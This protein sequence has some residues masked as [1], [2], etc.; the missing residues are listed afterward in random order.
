MEAK[1]GLGLSSWVRDGAGRALTVTEDGVASN[2]L[3]DG[4]QVVAEGATQLTLAPNGQT[5]SETTTTTTTKG[6]NTTTTVTSVDVL[7]DVLGSAVA[8]ASNGVISADLALFG[9]FGDPLTTSKT[10]T[11]TGFTGKLD[12]AGL[13]EFAVRTFDP[14]TRQWVQ[15]DRYRGTVTRAASMNRYAYVEGAPETFVD[16]LGFYRARAAIRAQALAAWEAANAAALAAYEKAVQIAY[17]EAVSYEQT[18]GKYGCVKADM[19]VRGHYG[20]VNTADAVYGQ[21][22]YISAQSIVAQKKLEAQERLEREARAK[23]GG[24]AG[25]GQ[26]MDQ[27]CVQAHLKSLG[28]DDGYSRSSS[29]IPAPPL[30]DGFVKYDGTVC[31]VGSACYDNYVKYPHNPAADQAIIDVLSIIGHGVVNFGGGAINAA[32]SL[33]NGFSG[34]VNWGNNTCASLHLCVD[35]PD[36]PAIPAIPIWGDYDLYRWSSYAGSATLQSVVIV[37]SG[38][39]GAGGLGADATT[40]LANAAGWGLIKG[41]WT[42]TTSLFGAG[43]TAEE[44]L[45][46]SRAANGG[47]G[48]LVAVTVKD[49]AAD[50]FAQRIGGAPSVRFANGPANEFDAVS[51]QYVAQAKPADF[52]LNQA[53]RNQAKATFEA[54]IASGRV[55]Y[56]QF[57]GPPGPGVLEALARYAERYGIDPVVDLKPLGSL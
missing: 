55:P 25:G 48:E 56:F 30:E 11:V 21:Y 47:L 8:T 15:D 57:D 40:A 36:I 20:F 34:A 12:T 17:K 10:D 43:R 22:G 45:A 39:I 44:A 24:G 46:T 9:D 3:Y 23:S 37:G 27:A 33:V 1:P 41:V 5:L 42:K 29:Y 13:V 49:P 4:I 2:R 26:C 52:T 16:E 50:A 32:S 28:M 19:E 51:A 14:A 38:G 35:I 6:K 54:A 31:A 53:F 18:C 7:T